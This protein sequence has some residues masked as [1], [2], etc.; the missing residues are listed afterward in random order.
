MAEP[1]WLEA[2]RRNSGLAL[3]RDGEWRY[4]TRTVESSRV[5]AMFHRGV[6]VRDDGEVT[7]SVGQM[8]AYVKTDG[9]AF[10]V[11]AV[12]VGEAHGPTLRLLGERVLPISE[13]VSAGWGPDDRLYLWLRGLAAQVLPAVCLREAHQ[14]LIARLEER[15]R[16][17]VLA[18]GDREIGVSMLPAI[19]SAA[20]PPPANEETGEH[21]GE[22]PHSKA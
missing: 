22:A 3:T 14:A 2:L 19:P 16:G 5:Q 6:A 8:W 18:F 20:A 7:L 11:R 15:E 17:H 13:V 10:F 4:G 1:E 12:N 21:S 9:P